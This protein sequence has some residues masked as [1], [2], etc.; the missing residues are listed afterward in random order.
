MG[1]V[2]VFCHGGLDPDLM[3]IT[4]RSLPRWQAWESIVSDVEEHIMPGVT[5]W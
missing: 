4:V 3:A 1:V 5:H 2:G